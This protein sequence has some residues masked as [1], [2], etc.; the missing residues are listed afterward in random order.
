MES[1]D[2][3]FKSRFKFSYSMVEILEN[4]QNFPVCSIKTV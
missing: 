2:S 3:K 4:D 1:L